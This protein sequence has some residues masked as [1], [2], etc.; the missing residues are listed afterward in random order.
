MKKSFYLTATL[1]YVNADPHM[2]HALEFVQSDAVARY[3]RLIGRD[4]FFSTGTDEHGQKVFESAQSAG[5]KDTKIYADKYSLR[6][7]ELL[8]VLNI[9]VDNFIRTTDP[10]HKKAAEEIWRRCDKAG[11]IYKKKYKGKYCVGCESF[12]RDTDLDEKGRCLLHLNLEIKVLEE[13]NYFFRFSKYQ[14]KLF[15]YLSHP[16]VILPEWRRGE[17]VKFVEGGLEDFSISREKERLSWGVPVPGDDSH[18]MYVWFDA[19]TN[20]ISTLGWPN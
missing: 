18:V 4:V 12:K 19:L 9:S 17:A 16:G 1:P 15:D 3:Q 2:G 5:E 10:L 6:F 13:E 20:Y 14:D 8:K 11:D 7:K